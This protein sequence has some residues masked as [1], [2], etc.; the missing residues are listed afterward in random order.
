MNAGSGNDPADDPQ[1]ALL[2][3]GSQELT[4]TPSKAAYAATTSNATNKVTITGKGTY[5]L[6]LNGAAL[7]NGEAAA[8]EEGENTLTVTVSNGASGTETVYTI[9]VTRGV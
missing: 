2:K 8:W 5:S 6:T 3:I 1:E 4:L 7:E 9:L